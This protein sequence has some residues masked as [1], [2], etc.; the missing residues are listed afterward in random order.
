MKLTAQEFLDQEHKRITLIGMSGAGKS[1]FSQILADDGWGHY[2]CDK[3][4]GTQYLTE[5]GEMDCSINTYIG[6]LGDPALG[7]MGLVEF[8]RRQRLHYDA[9]CEVLHDMRAVIEKSPDQNFVN[10]SSGSLCEIEDKAVMDRIGE[11]TLFV[12]LKISQADHGELLRRALDSPKSLYFPQRFFDERL[13]HYMD[14]FDVQ[15]ANDIHP[16]EFLR[17][18]FPYLFEARLPKYK[19]LA[20]R[21]G[22]S[23]RASDLRDIQSA[24]EFINV[25]AAALRGQIG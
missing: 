9:E 2:S 19:A 13:A 12:Y 17:W 6:R 11:D 25:V 22:V 8:S 21:Y 16:D 3:L 15:K 18:I 23:V 24:D 1:H 14:D 20:D 7:G 10:D 4:M 5:M